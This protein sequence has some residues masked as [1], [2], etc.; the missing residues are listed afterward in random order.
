MRPCSI[1]IRMSPI[2]ASTMVNGWRGASAAGARR[3]CAP[4]VNVTAAASARAA[5]NRNN[6]FMGALKAKV[7][8]RS[9]EHAAHAAALEDWF[10]AAMD[11]MSGVYKR[12]MQAIT[13][14]VAAALTLMTNADT[15]RMVGVLWRPPTQAAGLIDDAG[16]GAQ[17]SRAA[18]AQPPQ[19]NSAADD[20]QGE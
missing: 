19:A 16:L 20:A 10:D 5:N 6:S 11:R 12:R 3:V 4:R 17:R 15:L 14:A 8:A 7:A 2:V 18:P 9:P 1:A 13:I